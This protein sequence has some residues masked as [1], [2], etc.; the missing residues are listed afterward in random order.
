[1]IQRDNDPASI[2]LRL[3]EAA[4]RGEVVEVILVARGMLRPGPGA[5]RWR[6]RV[7]GRRVLSFDA[8]AAL[9]VTPVGRQR[10]GAR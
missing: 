1:V 10:R 8:N 3:S 9:A 2:S 4:E 5:G 7:D 6:L